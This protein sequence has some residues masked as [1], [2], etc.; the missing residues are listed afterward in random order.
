MKIVKN[1]Q[2]QNKKAFLEHLHQNIS[3]TLTS[4]NENEIKSHFVPISVQNV[5]SK[6]ENVLFFILSFA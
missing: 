3:K 2:L 4:L 6:D 5:P 1:C